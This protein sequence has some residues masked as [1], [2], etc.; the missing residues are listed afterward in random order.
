MRNKKNLKAS[1]GFDAISQSIESIISVNQT[2]QVFYLPGN[3]LIFL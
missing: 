2:T 1:S 3:L